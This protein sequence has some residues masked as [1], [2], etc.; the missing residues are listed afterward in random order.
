[1]VAVIGWLPDVGRAEA[2]QRSREL[3]SVDFKLTGSGLIQHEEER[4]KD[5]KRQDAY[6]GEP[7]ACPPIKAQRETG[8]GRRPLAVAACAATLAP[9]LDYFARWPR[10]PRF[11]QIESKAALAGGLFISR[12]LEL[13][14][15]ALL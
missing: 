8:S 15:L 3:M 11:T 12:R 6:H 7:P 13:T 9:G 1:M 5:E 10:R 14:P 4:T 2:L